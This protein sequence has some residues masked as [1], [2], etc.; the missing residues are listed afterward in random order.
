MTKELSPSLA[1]T[2]KRENKQIKKSSS[3]CTNVKSKSG[4]TVC[5]QKHP[6]LDRLVTL[7]STNTYMLV[8][9][10]DESSAV[11]ASE[12]SSCRKQWMKLVMIPSTPFF[13]SIIFKEILP[14]LMSKLLEYDYVIIGTYKG[15]KYKGQTLSTMFSLLQY[16]K[17]YQYDVIPFFRSRYSSMKRAVFHHRRSYRNAWDALLTEMN[18]SLHDI[19]T[20]DDIKAFHCNSY[21][22]RPAVLLKL[23][24]FMS[25]AIQV[26]LNNNKVKSLMSAN[27]FYAGNQSVAQKIFGTDYYQ[28]YPFIFERLPVFYLYSSHVSICHY[29]TGP[30][31]TNFDLL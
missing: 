21:I 14:N 4:K 19:R 31:G 29:E 17:T 3:N 23:T 22:I 18:Y 15:L 6:E 8:L 2:K 26:V 5:C 30:C 11:I 9:A 24:E 27:S 20:Y 10:H 28:L 1:L 7:K 16:A 25:R 13:E 12:F